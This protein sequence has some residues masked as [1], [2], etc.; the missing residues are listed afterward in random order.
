[1]YKKM[2]M[3]V[4]AVLMVMSMFGCG[5]S[6]DEKAI[7]D[8]DGGTTAETKEV[9]VE[10]GQVL[11]D[12]D[13]V[14]ITTQGF[15]KDSMWGAGIKVLVE[16]GSKKN[17]NVMIKTLV[18][19]GYNITNIFSSSVAA[20]K[21]SNETIYLGETDLQAAN[22]E[23]VA[24]VVVRFTVSDGDSYQTLFDTGDVE[25]KTSAY[26][27]VTQPA[28]DDGKELY[29]GKSIRIVG[30]YVDE[31]S[32]WGAGV[33]VY[34]QND[35]GKDVLVQCDDMSVNGFMVTPFFSCQVNKGCK[36]LSTITILSSD[37][38]ANGIESVDDIELKFNIIDPES[39]Q[40]IS[41]TGTIKFSTK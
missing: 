20:G 13:G 31:N 29:N 12:K 36:A 28:V 41:D 35:S 40:T 19:N 7:T 4:L 22:I 30:K 15:E 34:I 11:V 32:F 39:F 10:Q 24:D 25:I 37:L 6:G 23:T 2:M 3:T 14:K 17:I 8:A 16:N 1:M 9:T 21:K 27:T 38:E 33:L 5:S 18:V 26:G